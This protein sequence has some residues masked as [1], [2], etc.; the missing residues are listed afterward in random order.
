MCIKIKKN[1]LG[2]QGSLTVVAGHC[3]FVLVLQTMSLIL[4]YE[5]AFV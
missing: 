3:I 5:S 1:S 4:L 2:G